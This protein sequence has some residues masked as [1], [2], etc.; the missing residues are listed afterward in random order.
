MFSAHLKHCLQDGR[1]IKMT[2]RRNLWQRSKLTHQSCHWLL[3]LMGNKSCDS[4]GW[5]LMKIHIAVQV[6][7]LYHFK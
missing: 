5:M 3:H 6:F 1:N 7:V 4:I 2:L